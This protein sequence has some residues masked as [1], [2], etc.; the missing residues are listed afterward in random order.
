MS[1]PVDALSE[2][3]GWQAEACAA[4]VHYRGADD[5]YSIEY[6]APSDC[7]LYWKVKDDGESAVPIGRKNVP[8]PLRDR[9]R[10]D[11]AETGIDPSVERREI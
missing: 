3:D 4:R 6:Y 5:A 10:E 11:L 2:R 9:I 8:S 1:D 7:V